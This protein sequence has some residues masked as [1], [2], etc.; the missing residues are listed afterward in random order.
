MLQDPCYDHLY[1]LFDKKHLLKVPFISVKKHRPLVVIVFEKYF[2]IVAFLSKY[3]N[4]C[5]ALS[6]YTKRACMKKV[7]YI[8]SLHFLTFLGRSLAK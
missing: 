7:Q 6:W 4:N 5:A 2:M 3:P 8:I 1:L